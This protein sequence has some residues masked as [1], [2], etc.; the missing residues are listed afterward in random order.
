MGGGGWGVGGVGGGGVE[1]RPTQGS[2]VDYLI[3]KDWLDLF[4]LFFFLKNILT[5]HGQ[6]KKGHVTR[7][8][9]YNNSEHL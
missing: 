9:V 3:I 6:S 5:N 8:V 7:S 4:F 2:S 1:D